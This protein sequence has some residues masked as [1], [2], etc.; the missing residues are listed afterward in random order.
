MSVQIDKSDGG[1]LCGGAVLMTTAAV[2]PPSLPYLAGL[3]LWSLLLQV[4]AAAGV[5]GTPHQG[6][7]GSSVSTAVAATPGVRGAAVVRVT[8]PNQDRHGKYTEK[9]V[10]VQG[11]FSPMA[12]QAP[13]EGK[14]LQMHP[15]ALCEQMRLDRDDYDFGWVGFLRPDDVPSLPKKCHSIYEMARY[16][17]ER[18]ATALLVDVDGLAAAQE[19]LFQSDILSSGRDLLK[20]P[21]VV[22]NPKQAL[23][24]YDDTIRNPDLKPHA[25]ISFPSAGDH[26]DLSIFLTCF[27]LICLV[28]L[29]LLLKMRWR[30]NNKQ[31]TLTQQAKRALSRMECRRYKEKMSHKHKIKVKLKKKKAKTARSN[32][33][34]T[35]QG[36]GSGEACKDGE[37]GSGDEEDL[38]EDE[39]EDSQEV[40]VLSEGPEVCVVC[41]EEY[42]PHQELRVLPCKHEFHRA[43]VDPWLVQHR[44]C[45]LCNYNIIDCCYESPPAT[46]S[47]SIPS[48]PSAQLYSTPTHGTQYVLAPSSPAHNCQH[49]GC[50][51]HAS[52]PPLHN[53]NAMGYAPLPHG[54]VSPPPGYSSPSMYTGQEGSYAG[55]TGQEGSYAG[56]TSGYVSPA[57]ASPLGGY[58][59]PSSVYSMPHPGYVSPEA[60]Y[61]HPHSSY[62]APTLGFPTSACGTLGR[63]C[64][65]GCGVNVCEGAG[66]EG[67]Q[68]SCL[69]YPP[70]AATHHATTSMHHHHH[71]PAGSSSEEAEHQILVSLFTNIV[72]VQHHHGVGGGCG[73]GSSDSSGRATCG[74]N[75]SDANTSVPRPVTYPSNTGGKGPLPSVPLS[76]EQL[77]PF[78]AALAA[79]QKERRHGS[80]SHSDSSSLDN[81]SCEVQ[82]PTTPRT[83]IESLHNTSNTRV[84]RQTRSR[85]G[86]ISEGSG[87]PEVAVR[88]PRRSGAR[89]ATWCSPSAVGGS[90]TNE[91][92][93]YRNSGINSSQCC[94][95]KSR[96][97]SDSSSQVCLETTDM[98]C[99]DPSS[100]LCPD[101]IS[102]YYP[103]EIKPNI[104]PSEVS[105]SLISDGGI[106]VSP[107]QIERASP[108][109]SARLCQ[110][111]S[112]NV[113]LAS[114]LAMFQA[115]VSKDYQ[116]NEKRDCDTCEKR[117]Q[118]QPPTLEI[119]SSN[120]LKESSQSYSNDLSSHSQYSQNSI[121]QISIKSPVNSESSVCEHQNSV[122]HGH[123]NN[124]Y[125]HQNTQHQQEMPVTQ[126]LSSIPV[127]SQQDGQS[128]T[129]KDSDDSTLL[130]HMRT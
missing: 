90:Q 93:F 55:Y 57:Y 86:H 22:L 96:T 92:R 99:P 2:V 1:W 110:D 61:N 73:A 120:H 114:Y 67:V 66:S 62:C 127:E 68:N 72:E 65:Y 24:L 64:N 87:G 34:G 118:S 88:R 4:V 78:L 32:L 27:L 113:S 56:L 119:S 84:T 104:P 111:G 60:G 33:P 81:V 123:V 74:S 13:A 42:R 76:C 39:T 103:P 47:P 59:S 125:P 100:R 121:S 38:D 82:P 58:G 91:K 101:I 48:T 37:G 95:D 17:I 6:A 26:F 97:C 129:I 116:C 21:I 30:R 20:R 52:A 122:Q 77:E 71:P 14:L 41:L 3:L 46:C 35:I 94:N 85:H 23:K 79:L 115:S 50:T 18:G 51:I 130:S 11:T 44:T 124:H 80:E 109:G 83:S 102:D 89:R 19:E 45:P 28:C 31:N 9:E 128:S 75:S 70:P 107:E 12:L 36:D 5:G 98:C 25:R 112:V 7:A 126:D 15:L 63:M 54:Y 105:T 53:Y 40:S 43:C 29:A 106:C 16:A 8:V 49:P 108:D 69:M 117:S 10:T